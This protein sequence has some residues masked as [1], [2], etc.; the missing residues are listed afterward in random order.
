MRKVG[1]YADYIDFKNQKVVRNVC[2]EYITT[3]S[4]RGNLSGT[5]SVFISNIS[6]TPIYLEAGTYV[7]GAIS[8]KFKKAEYAWYHNLVKQGGVIS[9]YYTAS[10]ANCIAYT[11][12]DSSINTVESAQQSI[13]DGFEVCYILYEPEETAITT[14]KLPTIQGT[15]IYSIDTTVQPS[16]MNVTYYATSKE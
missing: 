7:W 3:V 16:N 8:N 12:S 11:F 10:Q 4:K 15:T 13:G 1:D 2:S 6:K 14:P 5:Y 9:S